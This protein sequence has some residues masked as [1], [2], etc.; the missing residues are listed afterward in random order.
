MEHVRPEDRA[1]RGSRSGARRPDRRPPRRRGVPRPRC[2][3][4]D[5]G[6]PPK[7]RVAC[8]GVAQS[9]ARDRQVLE[10]GNHGS[11]RDRT[12]A[13]AD[14][15]P[16]AA[17]GRAPPCRLPIQHRAPLTD[18]AIVRTAP[19]VRR[20]VRLPGRG[21]PTVHLRGQLAREGA[22]ATRPA[23]EGVGAGRPARR[24]RRHVRPGPVDRGRPRLGRRR[25]H[26]ARADHRASRGR[27]PRSAVHPRGATH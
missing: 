17:D 13:G 2:R 22:L 11:P 24:S 12:V 8:D 26:R 1:V 27:G 15:V 14:R 23:P 5:E 7:P 21:R 3:R 10:R 6:A 4:V 25:R 16:R 9:A 20:A 18:R 19:L